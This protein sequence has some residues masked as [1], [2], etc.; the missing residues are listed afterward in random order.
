[1]SSH[2]ILISHL[3]IIHKMHLLLYNVAVLFCFFR[4]ILLAK[5]YQSTWGHFISSVDARNGNLT[6]TSHASKPQGICMIS[7]YC[8]EL[9]TSNVNYNVMS[10][11]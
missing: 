4:V 11:S 3:Y 2:I 6:T 7:D 9:H 5:N 1:M 10:P 8:V